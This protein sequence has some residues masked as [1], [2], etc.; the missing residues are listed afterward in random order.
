MAL[1]AQIVLSILAHESSNGDISRTLRA[2][3]ANYSV[4]LTD[5]TGAN[6]A[7]VVWSSSASATTTPTD[8]EL[9]SLADTRDG[10]SVS[11]TFTAIK[12]VYVRNKSDSIALNIGGPAGPTSGAWFPA[13]PMSLQPGGCYLMSAPTASGIAVTP[14][15]PRIARLAAA[16]ENASYDI[17]IIGEG[18]VA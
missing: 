13:V 11:V 6:Q 17:V 14:S 10:A 1:N 16:S 12:A 18:S 3:P 15:G 7:Q 2:T 5:G 4:T 9:S 8:L